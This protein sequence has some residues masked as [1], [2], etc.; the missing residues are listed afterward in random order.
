MDYILT[1]YAVCLAL[2]LQIKVS[3]NGT[4]FSQLNEIGKQMPNKKQIERAGKST[5]V[6]ARVFTTSMLFSTVVGIPV[7]YLLSRVVG[8]VVAEVTKALFWTTQ[9]IFKYGTKVVLGIAKKLQKPAAALK[10]GL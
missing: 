3:F 7:Y 4:A 2:S 10:D 9:Q 1:S 5:W 8:P 6:F